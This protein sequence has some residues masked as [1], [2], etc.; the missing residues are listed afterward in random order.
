VD[1]NL[2]RPRV[3]SLDLAVERQ[4]PWNMN[5][6]VAYNHTHGIKLPR[7]R[8]FNIGP[9]LLDPYFCAAPASAG[10]Q[11]CGLRITKSYDIV[12]VNGLTQQ[13]ITLPFYSSRAA[14]TGAPSFSARLDPRT[15]VMNGNSSDVNSTYN[16]LVLTVR[17]PMRNGVEVLANYTFSR[18]TDNGQQSGG[19]PLTEGQSGIPASDPLNNKK[20][21]GHSGTD[22]RK[23]L[24]ATR[25]FVPPWRNNA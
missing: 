9:D 16:G 17:K 15:G 4:L 1:P 13:S 5:V 11:M 10:A 21:K 3:Y 6:S 18:A 12:D 2:R 25:I 14:M 24:S 19:K 22:N 7:G 20:E 8:D 23:R